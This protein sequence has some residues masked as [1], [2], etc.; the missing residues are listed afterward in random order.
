MSD[1][2]RWS[3]GA[4]ARTLGISPTTLRTWDRRYGLGPRTREEGKHRRYDDV[5]VATLRRMLELTGQGVSPAAAAT[6]ARG[7]AGPVPDVHDF[8]RAATQLD[9]PRLGRLA[10]E[11]IGALGVVDAWESV[12]TPFLVELGERAVEES[13][14]V[15]VEHVASNA[16]LT[17]LRRVGDPLEGGRLPALM[18]A[19]PDEQ[20]TLPLEAL[21]AALAERGCASRNLGARVPAGALLAALDVLAPRCVV[22]WAHDTARARLVPLAKVAATRTIL[23]LG[24]P[25]WDRVALPAGVHRV[26]TLHGCVDEVLTHSGRSS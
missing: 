22:L 9:A 15:G 4:V 24:G 21:G 5:D 13:G 8:I 6:M 19:A 14:G 23:L 12:L 20:H 11:L 10:T 26:H 7:G 18:A 16:L 3:A 2:A 17:V 1:G 25:G